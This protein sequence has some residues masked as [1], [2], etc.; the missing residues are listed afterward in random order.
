MRILL[1]VLVL[2][3]ASA[4]FGDYIKSE[5]AKYRK[6]VQAAGIRAE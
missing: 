6:V 3:S 1:A 2:A 4:K 5:I